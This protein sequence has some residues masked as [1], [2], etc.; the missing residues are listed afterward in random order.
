DARSCASSEIRLFRRNSEEKGVSEESPLS[1]WM[2]AASRQP[3]LAGQAE[4]EPPAST[5][6]SASL[7]GPAN[8][9]SYQELALS[10]VTTAMFRAS[11]MGA[12]PA[13]GLPTLRQLGPDLLC[14][15]PWRRLLSLALPFL[16]CGAY[17]AFAA[18]GWW[19]AAVLA[20][21]ALSFVTYGSTS[22]DLVHRSLGLPR[23]VN[24]W[25]LCLV[26]LLALRSGH[27]SQAA[28]LH[29]HARYPHA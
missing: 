15:P 29:H 22:H 18:S 20:L 14:V 8:P 11:L 6:T 5:S 13:V 3:R 17:F 16:W 26:E 7:S 21:V 2:A 23:A 9:G 10:A 12:S 19:A 1:P 4:S 24:D 25:L 28:H 27:A